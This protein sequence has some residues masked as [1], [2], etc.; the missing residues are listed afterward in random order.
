MQ[1]TNQHVSARS[2]QYELVVALQ[3]VTNKGALTFPKHK[4]VYMYYF[5]LEHCSLTF[6]TY[7]HACES[8]LPKKARVVWH[9]MYITIVVLLITA[10]VFCVCFCCR[11]C[12]LL[13]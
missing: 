3:H 2:L 12:P 11:W 10:P 5:R 4:S 6:H 8:R 1:V 13:L 9:K 7:V